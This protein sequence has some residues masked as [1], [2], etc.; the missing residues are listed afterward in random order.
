MTK[1]TRLIDLSHI[2]DHNPHVDAESPRGCSNDLCLTS[3]KCHETCHIHILCEGIHSC[4]HVMIEC[5]DSQ[6]HVRAFE[7]KNTD[8]H[9]IKQIFPRKS[10]IH[11]TYE[12]ST[13]YEFVPLIDAG[14]F[15]KGDAK[16]I[17]N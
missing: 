17:T 10:V 8:K 2:A 5:R 15:D 3:S 14:H 11:K 6:N 1:P 9:G 4:S 16:H 13:A 12:T 7:V